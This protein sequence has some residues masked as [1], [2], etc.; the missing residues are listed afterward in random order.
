MKTFHAAE[1]RTARLLCLTLALLAAVLHGVEAQPGPGKGAEAPVVINGQSVL[2]IPGPLGPYSAL[3]RAHIA[4]L[5]LERVAGDPS[6]SLR[7]LGTTENELGTQISAGDQ[8]LATV[9]D[10]DARA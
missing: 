4:R 9:T 6:I 2:V 10:A 7:S 5:R 3:E 8:L 1:G